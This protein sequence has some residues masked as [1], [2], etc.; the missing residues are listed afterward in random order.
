MFCSSC[1]KPIPENSA[2]CLHCGAAI[3]SKEKSRI[4]P[5]SPP[6]GM[7]DFFIWETGPT[8]VKESFLSTKIGRGFEVAFNLVDSANKLTASAGECHIALISENVWDKASSGPTLFGNKPRDIERARRQ[9]LFFTKLAISVNDFKWVPLKDGT[10]NLRF[11]YFQVAQLVYG[12]RNE[13]MVAHCWFQTSI[14]G[15]FYKMNY[16]TWN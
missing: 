8:D 11:T 12:P 9:A 16:T 6:I 13:W 3:S 5:T 1:G 10:E 4:I 7:N 2:F 15:L 14:G